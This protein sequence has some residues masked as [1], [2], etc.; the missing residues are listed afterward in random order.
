[1]S[2]TRN[3]NSSADLSRILAKLQPDAM[4]RSLLRAS[5]FLAAYETLF[6]AIVGRPFRFKGGS[7]PDLVV[8]GVRG[9]LCLGLDRDGKL[10]EDKWL[11]LMARHRQVAGLKNNDDLRAALLWL[12]E[13]GAF[14]AQ[15]AEAIVAFRILRGQVA[16]ELPEFV[17]NP[18]YEVRVEQFKEIQ[19]L[20]RIL[21]LFWGRIDVDINPD[22]D[23]IEVS[24]EDICSPI[25]DIM[26][27]MVRA[28]EEA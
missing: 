21:M 8:S 10:R 3:F 18:D 17:L 5:L 13:A 1:M 4:R 2:T 20:L 24:D 6:G 28:A 14:T 9:F 23:G 16:H 15:Q 11:D 7:G 19:E 27:M 22:F 26:E 12:V 25:V